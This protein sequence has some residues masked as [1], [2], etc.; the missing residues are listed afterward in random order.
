MGL[1]YLKDKET[2]RGRS[3]TDSSVPTVYSEDSQQTLWDPKVNGPLNN[4]TNGQENTK[5]VSYGEYIQLPER[6]VLYDNILPAKPKADSGEYMR[7]A[8]PEFYYGPSKAPQNSA[9]YY[10][11]Y[12]LDHSK[13]PFQHGSAYWARKRLEDLT[14]AKL[15]TPKH[16]VQNPP[17]NLVEHICLVDPKDCQ[18][19]RDPEPG[20]SVQETRNWEMA[21]GRTAPPLKF[22]PYTNSNGRFHEYVVRAKDQGRQCW[23]KATQIWY[24][25]TEKLKKS[26]ESTL[27]DLKKLPKRVAHLPGSLREEFLEWRKERNLGRKERTYQR[28]AAFYTVE[29]IVM[30]PI[31]PIKEMYTKLRKKAMKE[32][33]SKHGN[34][35]GPSNSGK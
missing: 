30:A 1:P 11:N 35:N 12:D 15:E 29:K 16:N 19:H 31:I 9:S 4:I 21:T 27:Q 14:K 8:H 34:S 5:K 22:N 17:P 25:S 26:A 7:A 32:T 28:H 2:V 33:T 24:V 3:G 13:D 20:W 6:A 23:Y 18:F 10:T